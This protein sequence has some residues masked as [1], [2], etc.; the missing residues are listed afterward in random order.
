MTARTVTMTR[1]LGSGAEAIGQAVAKDLG[2]EYVDH[3]VIDRASELSGASPETIEKAE[4]PKS[5]VSRLLGSLADHV[6]ANDEGLTVNLRG[7]VVYI[8]LPAATGAGKPSVPYTDY[9][10]LIRGVIQEIADDGNAVIVAHGAAMRLAARDDVLR[11]LLTASHDTRVQRVTGE[12]GI[13]TKEATDC[14]DASD[15]ARAHYLRQF[16]DV[17][18]ENPTQYDLVVNTDKLSQAEAAAIIVGAAR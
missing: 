1:T 5:L 9:E 14:V 11:V 12:Q 15:R 16:Y 4:Q 6:G 17:R 3:G 13:S 8:A 10:S 7:D 2:F 18:D